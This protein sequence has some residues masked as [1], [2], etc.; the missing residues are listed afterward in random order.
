MIKINCENCKNNCCGAIKELRPILLSSE[1]ERFRESS[2]V[3]ITPFRKMLVLK[4]NKNGY[5]VFF[6]EKIRGCS[7]YKERP[8][9]CRLY[10]F[11]LDFSKENVD[12]KLDKRFCHSLS[13][14]EFD[15]NRITSFVRTFKFPKEWVK[16][17]ES[18]ENF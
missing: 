11:L 16:G 10:P 13:L 1:E 18:M 14:L 6:D 17:Y 8:L 4:R 9:E 12:V 7:A 15:K 3:I 5:C 2:E